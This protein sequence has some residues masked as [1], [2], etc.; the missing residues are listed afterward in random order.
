[1]YQAISPLPQRKWGKWVWDRKNDK[2]ANAIRVGSSREPGHS[3]SP[4]MS[5]NVRFV[6]A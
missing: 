3:G 6:D 5:N 1:M 2:P 4:V